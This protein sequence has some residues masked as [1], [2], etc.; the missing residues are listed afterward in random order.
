[1][2]TTKFKVGD[3]YWTAEA[4]I[5]DRESD[6]LGT[7]RHTPEEAIEDA[8]AWAGWLSSRERKLATA[9]IRCWEVAAVEDD[10][11]I[12]AAGT[13]CDVARDGESVAL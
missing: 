11:T 9:W 8:Q 5:S 7:P 4:K 3:L 6:E 2:E 10:G 12:G 13:R 1:M